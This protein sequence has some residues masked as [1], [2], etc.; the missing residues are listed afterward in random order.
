VEFILASGLLVLIAS[1][2]FA[3]IA[4]LFRR[5]TRPSYKDLL[6][7]YETSKAK[8]ARAGLFFIT[9]GPDGP[10]VAAIDRSHGES[11]PPLAGD[12]AGTV[13]RQTRRTSEGA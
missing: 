1:M 7:D 9:A 4:A 6:T 2:I 12:P 10:T 8:L 3:G 13:S 11:Y 5:R